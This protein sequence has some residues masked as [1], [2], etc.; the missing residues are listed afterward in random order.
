MLL[1]NIHVCLPIDVHT[2]CQRLWKRAKVSLVLSCRTVVHMINLLKLVWL[3]RTPILFFIKNQDV[4]ATQRVLF[5][6]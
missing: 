2:L 5:S 1:S 4:S 6:G 3:F